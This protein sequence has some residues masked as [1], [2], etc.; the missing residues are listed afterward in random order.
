[1]IVG[2][3]KKTFYWSLL[4]RG[5]SVAQNT[6]RILFAKDAPLKDEFNYL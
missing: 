1:M 3:K 2:R 6:D 4:R 5:E